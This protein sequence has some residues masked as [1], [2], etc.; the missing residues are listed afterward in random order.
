[1][2]RILSGRW[3]LH[4]FYESEEISNSPV[5]FDVYDPHKVWMSGQEKGI[6]GETI[7]LKGSILFLVRIMP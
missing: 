7:N 2:K 6:V 1:M 4:A 5:H 3:S